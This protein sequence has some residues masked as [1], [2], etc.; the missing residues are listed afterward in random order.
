MRSSLSHFIVTMT[1]MWHL[2]GDLGACCKHLG[3]NC[4]RGDLELRG[5]GAGRGRGPMQRRLAARF[6]PC[7]CDLTGGQSGQVTQL[8]CA[9]ESS[10]PVEC[11]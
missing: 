11:R 1:T 5:G 4:R 6:E 7:Y 2:R 8:L 3:T 10:S 9:W